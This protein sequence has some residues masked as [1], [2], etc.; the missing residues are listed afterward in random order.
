MKNEKLK[1][2]IKGLDTVTSIKLELAYTYGM[3]DGLKEGVKVAKEILIDEPK[4]EKA[5]Q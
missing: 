2:L 4:E 5:P 3:Q 1:E